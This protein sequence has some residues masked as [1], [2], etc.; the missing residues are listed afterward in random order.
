MKPDMSSSFSF[1]FFALAVHQLWSC[2]SA[3]V[4]L[5]LLLF[6]AGRIAQFTFRPYT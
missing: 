5:S 2:F 6:Y 1:T 3:L 4:A